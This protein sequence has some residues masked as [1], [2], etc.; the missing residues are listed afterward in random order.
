V[1]YTGQQINTL[2]MNI[3]GPGSSGGIGGTLSTRS[4]NTKLSIQFQQKSPLE[5]GGWSTSDYKKRYGLVDRLDNPDN[6]QI[7][8]NK[9][10]AD[11]NTR[12]SITDN[13]KV[14]PDNVDGK[15]EAD[16]TVPK[17]GSLKTIVEAEKFSDDKWD[18]AVKNREKPRES[19]EKI[20]DYKTLAYGELPDRTPTNSPKYH[21]FLKPGDV[22][23]P[24]EK[25]LSGQS[26]DQVG[27]EDKP[28]SREAVWP[29]NRGGSFQEGKGLTTPAD[30]QNE[31]KAMGYNE[32]GSPW[33]ARSKPTKDGNKKTDFGGGYGD[34]GSNPSYTGPSAGGYSPGGNVSKK[35]WEFDGD[36]TDQ[37]PGDMK[38]EF[39]GKFGGSGT[40]KFKAYLTSLNEAFAPG[41][42]GAQDQGRA[43]AR[44]LYTTFERTVSFE[45][46][47]DIHNKDKFKEVWEKLQKLALMTYPIYKSQGFHGEITKVT[48]GKM[49]E[50][51]P[52]IITDLTYDWDNETPWEL[53]SSYHMPMRTTVSLS[54]TILGDGEDAKKFDGEKSKV[55][56]YFG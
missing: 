25:E 33:G 50:K 17:H 27:S 8:Y 40:V 15:G 51:V 2:S 36:N 55:W 5:L 43:D 46:A 21:D 39:E 13:V 12:S 47:V 53:D 32:I 3:G 37:N 26:Y 30:G 16:I 38:F 20:K 35:R 7:N 19:A 4:E 11:I 48:L 24:P 54:C 49:Y 34:Y 18:G 31:F 45:F 1:G 56:S 10:Y 29:H 28:G 6:A 14:N 22:T 42:E 9:P 52:M 23:T 44:Y 41:W